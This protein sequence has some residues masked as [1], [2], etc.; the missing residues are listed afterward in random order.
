MNRELKSAET[1]LDF[2]ATILA[3]PPGLYTAQATTVSQEYY[4]QTITEIK[5]L[6]VL[7]HMSRKKRM[8][9]R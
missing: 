6:N 1:R 7:L 5:L 4:P 3:A 2:H 8:Q 9:V